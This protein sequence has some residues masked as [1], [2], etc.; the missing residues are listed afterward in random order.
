[1]SAP[2]AIAGSVSTIRVSQ[3]AV[4]MTPHRQHKLVYRNA[5][6]GGTSLS[7]PM[8]AGFEADLIQGRHH[9]ALGFANPTLYNM[10]STSAFHDVTSNPQGQ[11]IAEAAVFGPP[12][13]LSTMGLCATTPA[14]QTCGAGYDTTSGI[15]SPGPS[16]FSSSGSHPVR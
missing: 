14:H 6:N 13:A 4:P 9:I 10:A 3:A 12:P 5:V 2:A 16:F 7:S 11:G 8:F 1:M 15:G